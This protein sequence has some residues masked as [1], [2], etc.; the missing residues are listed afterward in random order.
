[1][2]TQHVHQRVLTAGRCR[3]LA[4]R[5]CSRSSSCIVRRQC[6]HAVTAAH[7]CVHLKKHA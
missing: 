1:M 2:A 3:W 4:S 7:Q 6:H 5:T